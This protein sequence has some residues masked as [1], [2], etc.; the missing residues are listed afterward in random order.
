VTRSEE[1]VP[2]AAD[3]SA[4]AEEQLRAWSQ[5]S[6]DE[7]LRWLEDAL[8]FAQEVGALARDR[9]QRQAAADR[10]SEEPPSGADVQPH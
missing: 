3:W 4:V 9:R 8:P 10:W 6:A 7:R 2:W 1:G 5:T